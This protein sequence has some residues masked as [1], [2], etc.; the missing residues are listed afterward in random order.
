MSDAIKTGV[1]ISV[2]LEKR[3]EGNPDPYEVTTETSWH[4]ADGGIITDKERIAA[5]EAANT[6]ED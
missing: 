6:E 1:K 4:D 3:R 5:L 2:R